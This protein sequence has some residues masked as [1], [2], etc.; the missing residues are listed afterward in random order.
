[1]FLPCYINFRSIFLHFAW[2]YTVHTDT[3]ADA[4]KTVRASLAWLVCR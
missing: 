2:T 4:A 1:M 3:L